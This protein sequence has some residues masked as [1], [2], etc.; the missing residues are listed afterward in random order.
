MLACA[1][2]YPY[3]CFCKYA[4]LGARLHLR[5]HHSIA[6]ALKCFNASCR[7]TKSQTSQ[8]AVVPNS[9]PTPAPTVT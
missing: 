9:F 7:H 4:M 2:M 8:G 1:Y 3:V 6:I 5:I